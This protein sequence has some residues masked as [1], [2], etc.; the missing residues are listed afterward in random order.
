[1]PLAQLIE[2]RIA[3]LDRQIADEIDAITAGRGS[4]DDL[5]LLVSQ[6]SDGYD[7]LTALSRRA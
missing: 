5:R 3:E 2:K 6:R 7:M 1:M 4:K